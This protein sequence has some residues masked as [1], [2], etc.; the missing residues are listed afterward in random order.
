MFSK[1]MYANIFVALVYQ[2]RFFLYLYNS[3]K[4]IYYKL[5][6][7]YA[8]YAFAFYLAGG[9]A[10]LML[11]TILA[12]INIMHLFKINKDVI[13]K[14]CFTIL[15]MYLYWYSKDYTFINNMPYIALVLHL[16]LKPHTK[17]IINGYVVYLEKLLI[18]IY[19]YNY[20]LYIMAIYEIYQLAFLIISKYLKK[21][22]SFFQKKIEP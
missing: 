14:L 4:S 21:Y 3:K 12:S 10:G 13:L 5:I 8:A 22:V 17:K 20:K 11:Y 18:I 9:S 6:F 15:C 16:W 1:I 2:L 19:A 7:T